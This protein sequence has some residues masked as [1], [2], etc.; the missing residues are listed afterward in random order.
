MN[1]ITKVMIVSVFTNIFLA[2]SKIL[3]GIIFSSASL[4]ADGIHSFSDLTT[5]FFAII[6]N[7]LS[8]KPADEEHPF[9]HG[10]LEYLTS[11]IIGFVVL[12]V[13]FGVVYQSTYSEVIIPNK[14]VILVSTITIISKYYLSKF[15][16]KKGIKYNNNILVASGKESKADVISSF[17][18][19]FSSILMQFNNDIEILKYSDIVAS[20][21]VGIFIIKT[22][23]SIIK[24][25]V[26]VILGEQEKDLEYLENIKSII[27]TNDT[28]LEI[29][30]MIIVKYGQTRTLNLTIIMIGEI[31]LSRAHNIV[32]II[33]YKLKKYDK[34][35]KHINIHMEPEKK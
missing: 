30:S 33:E 6:G 24:E 31:S 20:I 22:G 34:R 11:L 15:I 5:D 29:N 12:F 14:F 26:S 8:K 1:K 3:S 28:V 27:L 17:V 4:I 18:V 9:G 25:N 10:K 19:L 21:I 7:H 16:I 13:G 35:I 2:I 23:F 32:D